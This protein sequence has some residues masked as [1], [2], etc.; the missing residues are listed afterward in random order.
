M[1]FPRRTCDISRYGASPGEGAPA[2]H[3][4]GLRLTGERRRG[5]RWGEGSVTALVAA[6]A[7]SPRLLHGG[8]CCADGLGSQLAFCSAL[9]SPNRSFPS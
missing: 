2:Q 5:T 1:A 3:P 4:V 7:L 9:Q 6:A 8:L